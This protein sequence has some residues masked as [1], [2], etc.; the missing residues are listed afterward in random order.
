MKQ[1]TKTEIKRFKKKTSKHNK[2]IVIIAENVQYAKNV[3]SLF[4]IAD[5]VKVQKIILTGIS[6][7]PPFGKGL[8]KV[9]RNKEKSVHWEYSKHSG[10]PINKLKRK[11]YQ[12]IGLELT[13]ESQNYRNLDYPNKTCIVIGNET[14]GIVKTT[15]SKLEKAVY[16]PMYGK[17]ASLNVTTSCAVLLYEIIS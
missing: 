1:L 4:R 6:R 9:S 11:G 8:R 7:K 10:K 2:N 12:I 14:Y 13:D 15:L 3:A 5:A 16:I 17:G